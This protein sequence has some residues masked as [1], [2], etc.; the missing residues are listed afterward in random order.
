MSWGQSTNNGKK[1]KNHQWQFAVVS[2]LGKILNAIGG[3]NSGNRTHN[4][5]STVVAG[6]IPAGTLRGSVLNFGDE[7]GTWNGIDIPAGVTIPWGYISNSDPYQI[8]NYDPTGP[9]AGT[10]FIIEYTT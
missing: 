9:G 2:L 1:G 10:T 8:I 3:G 7:E 6:N 4:T 5:V